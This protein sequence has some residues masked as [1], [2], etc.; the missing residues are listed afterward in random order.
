M[1][2]TQDQIQQHVARS[3]LVINDAPSGRRCG[4]GRDGQGIAEALFG[5]DIGYFAAALPALRETAQR[6]SRSILNTQKELFDALNTIVQ[7]VSGP[8][9]KVYV[10]TDNHAEP[11]IVAGGCGFFKLMKTVPEY[12]MNTKDVKA[13]IAYLSNKQDEGKLIQAV[14]EGSHQE[15]AVVVV[16][17]NSHS[18]RGNDMKNGTSVFVLQQTLVLEHLEDVASKLSQQYGLNKEQLSESMINW[19]NTQTAETKK[20]LAADKPLVYADIAESGEI[21]LSLE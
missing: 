7:T 19:F 8:E 12:G 2:Y 14:Y 16:R 5:S 4:D 20:A 15:G 3:L 13:I 11:D 17:S 1:I 21:A 6:E 18:I 9:E 10:H